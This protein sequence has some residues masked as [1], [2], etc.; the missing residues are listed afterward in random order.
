MICINSVN[1]YPNSAPKDNGI[2]MLGRVYLLTAL[3]VQR[4]DGTVVTLLLQA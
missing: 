3:N 2:T 1:V 4:L